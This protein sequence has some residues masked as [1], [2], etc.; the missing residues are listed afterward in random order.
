MI[1]STLDDLDRRILQLLRREGRLSAAELG[2]RVGLSPSPTQRRVANL[3]RLGVIAGYHADVDPEALGRSF[4]VVVWIEL[5]T[6]HADM[7]DEFESALLAIDEVVS[8]RRLFGQ[9]D[10]T[11]T[12]AVADAAAYERLRM[13]QLGRL[14]HV[15]SI[16]SQLTMKALRSDM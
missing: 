6:A 16:N 15:R 14:P 9:P 11:A 4:E 13:H 12:V 2:R 8:A 7:I 10:Y 5:E 3:E 1:E